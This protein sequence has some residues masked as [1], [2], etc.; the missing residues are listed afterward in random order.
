[1]NWLEFIWIDLNWLWIDLNWIELAWIHMQKAGHALQSLLTNNKRLQKVGHILQV[2]LI[3]YKR[4]QKVRHGLQ[5][6][7]IDYKPLIMKWL[8]FI[9]ILHKSTKSQTWITSF[10]DRLQNIT[11]CTWWLDLNSVW[12]HNTWLESWTWI[13]QDFLWLSLW[14][15]M[16]LQSVPMDSKRPQKI[17]HTPESLLID[18]KSFKSIHSEFKSNQVNP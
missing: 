8:E 11:S 17:R 15:Q 1:M 13:Q 7:L 9:W 2:L 12:I 6:L 3:E 14:T 5:I 18:Y 16:R 4:I 10:T